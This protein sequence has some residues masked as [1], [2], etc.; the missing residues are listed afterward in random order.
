[1]LEAINRAGYCLSIFPRILGDLDVAGAARLG[2]RPIEAIC[3]SI[4]GAKKMMRR[5]S[6]YGPAGNRIH[7]QGQ[8]TCAP[9][10]A[11]TTYKAPCPE[12]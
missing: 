6:T 10:T 11:T 7:P 4:R 8:I 5:A 2:A 9:E 1:L 3:P 12:K